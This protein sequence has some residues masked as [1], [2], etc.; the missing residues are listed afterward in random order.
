MCMCV[1]GGGV[2]L[3]TSYVKVM[4]VVMFGMC[5]LGVCGCGV[6]VVFVIRGCV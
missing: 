5:M 1:C 6:G 3:Y 2:V 4:G